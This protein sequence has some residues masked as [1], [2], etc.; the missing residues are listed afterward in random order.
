VYLDLH[1]RNKKC[2]GSDDGELY[3]YTGTSGSAYQDQQV[4]KKA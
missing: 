1:Q 2:V 3:T 4:V